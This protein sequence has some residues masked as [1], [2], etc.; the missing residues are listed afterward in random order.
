MSTRFDKKIVSN[1]LIISH[2]SKKNVGG[3]FFM[4]GK[5]LKSSLVQGAGFLSTQL[6]IGGYHPVALGMFMAVWCSR[7]IRFPLFPIMTIG[8][9][10]ASGLLVGIKYGLVMFTI[11]IVYYIM[12]EKHQRVPIWQGAMLGGGVL[13]VMEI[14]DIYMSG[15]ETKQ[16]I[17]ALLATLLA[18]SLSIIFYRLINMMQMPGNKERGRRDK[19]IYKEVYKEKLSSYEERMSSISG[20]FAK[21][22]KSVEKVAEDGLFCDYEDVTSWL[23]Y[24]DTYCPHCHALLRQNEIYKHKLM[25]SKKVIATQL[26]EMSRILSECLDNTYDLK[27]VSKDRLDKLT[28]RFKEVGIVMEKIVCLDNK[29]GISEII[30]TMKSKRGRCVSVRSV[31]SM[32]MDVF[33]KNVEIVKEKRRVVGTEMMTYRFKEKPNY[34]VMHGI[35]KANADDVSGDNFSCMELDSGQTLLGIS[36]GMGSG[37]KAYRDSEMVLELLENLMESG[38]SEDTALKLINT[39]FVLEGENVAPATVD[40]GIIDRYSGM[41][42]FMKLGA[43]STYV[44]RGE[45]WVEAIRSTS[46]PIGGGS[47]PDIESTAKKLYDGD[48]VIMMSDGIIESAA[49]QDKEDVLGQMILDMKPGKPQDM[50]AELL[51]RACREFDVEDED[52]MTVLVT[53]IWNYAKCS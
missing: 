16:Y 39:I 5:I 9:V 7:L 30:I 17:L 50:A 14:I 43:A 45:S 49:R 47:T 8:I 31:A 36:D 34:Y 24:E 51:K 29:K 4:K 10:M 52:D 1:G 19:D 26:S 13:G 40:M 32:L 22:A 28:Q 53:G 2:V 15:G 35:A 25:D 3:Y 18:V 23:T 20:A 6:W 44:K 38:F 46:M 21:M 12:G 41:C 42:D 48:F 11:M 37:I 27:S 33:G